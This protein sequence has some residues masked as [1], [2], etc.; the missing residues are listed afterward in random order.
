[1]NAVVTNTLT[2][3]V[4]LAVPSSL[5]AGQIPQSAIMACLEPLIA[6]IDAL[7]AR[8]AELEAE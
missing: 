8:L 2:D 3:R 6:E 1:M 4:K 5:A 7:R